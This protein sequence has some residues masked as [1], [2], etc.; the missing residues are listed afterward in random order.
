M[1]YV[2]DSFLIMRKFN[3]AIDAVRRGEAKLF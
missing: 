3:E 1:P 2:L